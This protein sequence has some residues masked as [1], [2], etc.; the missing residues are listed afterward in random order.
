MKDFDWEVLYELYK[1]PNMTKVANILYITQP[2]LTKRLQHIEAE[3]DVTIVERTP[4]GL[5]FTPEGEYLAKQAEVYLRFLKQTRSHL[6]EMHEEN[7][8][9][10]NI[11]TSYTYGKYALTDVLMR[12]RMQFPDVTVSIH[13]ASSH[14]LFRQVVEGSVDVAFVRGDYG[15]V[16]NKLFVGK[17]Q[18]YLMTKSPI[19]DYNELRSMERL[20]YITNPESQSLITKWWE[21]IFHEAP[22]PAPV[23]GYVDNVWQM[24]HRGL[25]YTV[26]F[27]PEEYPNP[28]G[29]ALHPLQY[30]DGTPVWRNT[31]LLWS[32]DKRVSPVTEDFIQFYG[33]EYAP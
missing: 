15:D 19:Q 1:N 29:L 23:M 10:L 27:I 31:W 2:S 30:A 32:K 16:V 20:G 17:N 21:E 14:L 6:V 28:Y 12:Y 13:S 22:A 11:G 8:K 7:R 5:E 4:K 9:V 26:C 3:F 25:G 33:S 18:A 24:V